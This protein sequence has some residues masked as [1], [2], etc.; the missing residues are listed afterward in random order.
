MGYTI[1][2]LPHLFAFRAPSS[3][4]YENVA[5]FLGFHL[6][7]PYVCDFFLSPVCFNSYLVALNI[8][9]LLNIYMMAI[10]LMK[11]HFTSAFICPFGRIVINEIKSIHRNIAL[12]IHTILSYNN[13]NRKIS[14]KLN[15]D[16]IFFTY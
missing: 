4:L 12:G 14:L 11:N 10:Q 8:W 2:Y 5:K 13:N 6:T 3:Q 9:L 1:Y 16:N 7:C 15:V